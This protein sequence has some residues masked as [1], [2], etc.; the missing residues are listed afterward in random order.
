MKL[1]GFLFP[2]FVLASIASWAQLPQILELHNPT[3]LNNCIAAGGTAWNKQTKEIILSV[4]HNVSLTSNSIFYTDETNTF[5]HSNTDGSLITQIPGTGYVYNVYHSIL[6]AVQT[7]TFQAYTATGT[8]IKTFTI[9]G[10]DVYPSST[11]ARYRRNNTI[12]K[13]DFA[14]NA[15]QQLGTF[16]GT[17]AGWF[18]D[19]KYFLTAEGAVARLY[20]KNATQIRLIDFGSS[21]KIGGNGNYIWLQLFNEV[22]LYNIS[23][24]TTTSYPT[25]TSG[26]AFPS[27]N[28]IAIVRYGVP[29]FDVVE[30]GETGENVL[31]FETAIP[32]IEYFNA[33]TLGNWTT[34]T[35][36]GVV[37]YGNF[38][39]TDVEV[40][41]IGAIISM[42]GNENGDLA[43][44]TS[45]GHVLLYQLN[46]S[47]LDVVDTLNISVRKI[48]LSSDGRYLAASANTPATDPF[49]NVERPLFIYDL[50]NNNELVRTWR[51]LL[52]EDDQLPSLL[53]FDFSRDGK[54]VAQS[55][56]KK[57]NSYFNFL[58]NVDAIDSVQLSTDQL[59]RAPLISSGGN[60]VSTSRKAGSGESEF[61]KIY[62]KDGQLVNALDGY[63]AGWISDTTFVFNK[64]D[65][66]T[67]DRL[68]CY[69]RYGAYIYSVDGNKIENL[70]IPDS[71]YVEGKLAISNN[72]NPFYSG[73]IDQIDQIT[74]VE[75][76]AYGNVIN[77]ETDSILFAFYKTPL[78][79]SPVGTDYIAYVE[80][81]ELQLINWRTQ[82][83][84]R[85][86]DADEDGF[87]DND[88]TV[89]YFTPPA[90][91]VDN[92]DDCNDHDKLINPNTIWYIDVDGDGFGYSET[93]QT[94]CVAPAGYVLDNT[95]CNDDDSALTPENQCM[96]LAVEDSNG[97][98][99]AF[100]N[101][102]NGLFTINNTGNYRLLNV[103]D[104]TGRVFI[105]KAVD[106]GRAIYLDLGSETPGLYV[107]RLSKDGKSYQL[108]IVKK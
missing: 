98:L 96:I 78:V 1:S 107:A 75:L 15:E 23:A 12:Y 14:G 64:I 37:N 54:S 86:R 10:S 31:N 55:I 47:T 60:F 91:Y 42:D 72:S 50:D 18:L 103:V 74:A 57:G 66:T 88:V 3:I 7:G 2:A 95:D 32:Q 46:G 53:S 97:D 90:G 30:F 106:D 83:K 21:G 43:V 73:G 19:G 41:N 5:I 16:A 20:D 61:A 71:L 45:S 49:S 38:S 79:S 63:I 27:I 34:S 22:L 70:S 28:S 102:G 58:S 87:G 84:I 8:L 29:S 92:N 52:Y 101:P 94:G 81:N 104:A 11:D 65:H 39:T 59:G 77:I 69:Y 68:E 24:Q 36:N 62:G 80:N 35:E 76:Y 51:Y 56:L 40:L 93:H 9:D 100:P 44:A 4:D 99:I 13:Y 82:Y 26:E 6:W 17:F 105:P 85:Y 89:S 33:D 25:G 67:C 48:Q 108:K